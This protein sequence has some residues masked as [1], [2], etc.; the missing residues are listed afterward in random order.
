MFT[1]AEDRS[2]G[3]GVIGAAFGL[4]FIFGPALGGWLGQWGPLYPIYLAAALALI[5]WL[6]IYFC[7]PETLKR[8][9]RDQ[10][11]LSESLSFRGVSTHQNLP[12]LL[13]LAFGFTMAFALME[14]T[15]GLFIER[16]WLHEIVDVELRHSQAAS[17]TAYFLV[18][19]GVGASII[20]RR[21]DW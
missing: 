6:F 11:Q 17:L 15:V 14:Q 18:A 12:Q 9:E 20:P 5:N 19:V 4:G 10:E 8:S 2:R 3:M 1:S 13:G 7:L 21:I 16:A